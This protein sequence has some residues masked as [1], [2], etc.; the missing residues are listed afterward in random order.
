MGKK[1]GKHGRKEKAR[2][3]IEL[4]EN[5]KI[6]ITLIIV[7]VLIVIGITLKLTIFNKKIKEEVYL[8][9]GTEEITIL[10]FLEKER[11][12]KDASFVTD[13]STID[14]TKVGEYPVEIQYK[15][16]NY[17]STLKIQDTTAPKVEFQD[18]EKPVNYEIKAEDFIV[19]KEDKS[20]ITLEYQT[21]GEI[22]T[23]ELRRVYRNS[24]GKR[25]LQ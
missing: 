3:K 16:K 21:Q 12:Q 7:L 13:I 15:E 23:A 19:S 4:K 25:C 10:N 9:L 14:L 22:N 8:E 5:K 17:T 11:Y 20:E 2:T 24:Y 6:I 1:K 18:I